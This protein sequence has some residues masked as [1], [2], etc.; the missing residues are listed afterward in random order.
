MALIVDLGNEVGGIVMP[1]TQNK[2]MFKECTGLDEED[3]NVLRWQ[4]V[5][6]KFVYT[7]NLMASRF[8]L[9]SLD[10]HKLVLHIE[11]PVTNK[12]APII[13]K[14]MQL[15]DPFDIVVDQLNGDTT[16]L[17]STTYRN[18]QAKSYH[19]VLDYASSLP[20]VYPVTFSVGSVEVS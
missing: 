4:L 13:A 11:E 5:K 10:S 6:C 19:H 9:E 15:S 3:T 16:V 12:V 7:S 14:L 2:W 17:K 18:C 1:M 8:G 20:C